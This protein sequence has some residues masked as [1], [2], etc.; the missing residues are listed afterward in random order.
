MKGDE[1]ENGRDTEKVSC[2]T[3]L[4]SFADRLDIVLMFVGTIC[5][6]A[7]GLAQPLMTLILGQIINTFGGDSSSDPSHIIS[8]VSKV[9]LEFVYL[10]IGIAIA[11]FFQVSCWMVTGE[12]QAARIRGLYLK[13]ILRQDITFFDTETTTGEV[14]GRMSGDTILIQDAIGEKVGKTIQLVSTFLGGLVIAFLRGWLLTLVLLCCVPFIMAVLWFLGVQASKLASREQIAYAEAGNIVE[15]TIGAI[16]TVASYTGEKVAIENY[17]RSIAIAYASSVKQGLVSGFGIGVLLLVIFSSYGLAVWFGSKLIIHHGYNGGKVVNVMFAIMTGGMSLGYISPSFKAFVAG[18]AAAY[19]MFQAINRKPLIDSYNTNGTVPQEINGDI[20]LKDVYFSYPAR[21]DIQVFSGF[22]F[23]VPS[24]TTAALVGQ[25]GSGKSTVISLIERFYDPCEGEVLIDGINLKNLQLKWIREKIG[26]VSQE[27]ILFTTTIKGNIAYGKENAT[28]DEIRAANAHNFISGLPQGYDTSVGERGVQ[29]SGGQKQRIAISRAILK[30]P[31]ILLLDEATSALD[32]ESERIVQ[33]ALDKVMVNRTTIVVAHR[34]S[35]IKNADIIAVVKNGVI[36]ESGRHEALM[37]IED[38]AYASLVS[39]H[40]KSVKKFNTSLTGHLGFI[41]I[42][43]RKTKMKDEK[44]KGDGMQ[45]KG[46]DTEKVAYYKL[47]TFADRLD[48]VLMIIGT[49]SAIANGL[50]QPLMTLI[51]GQVINTFGSS[52]PSHIVSD[53]SKVS[54]DFVYLAIGAAIAS[55]CQVSCWMVTGERQAARIRGMYLKTILGQDITFFD[56]ETTTGEVIGRMSGDTILIQDAM[57]EKVGKTIQLLSTFFGGFVIAFIKGWLLALVLVS[58]IP[59]LVAAGGILAVVMSK[60]ASRGQ[61]AYAEAGNIVEQTIGAIRTVASFTG[62]KAAIEKYDR[63][64]AIAYTSAVKQGLASGFGIGSLLLVL[65]STYGLAVWFGSKM[66]I[67]KGYNGGQVVN[68]L[69]AIMTGGMSLGNA[70]PCFNAFASGQAAAYKMFQAINRKPLIDSYDKNGVVPQDIKGDIELKDVYFRY[71]ARPD[72]QIFSGFSLF[73]PSGKTAALVGQSGSGKSTVIS[74]IE[75]FY[76]PLEGE[77]LIDGINLKNLQ[78]KWIREKIGLVSQEPILFTTTIKGNI[79]YG[80]ENATD[81]EIRT[82]IKLA[83]A[84]KFIDKLPKGLD[85]MVGERGT[86]L[87]GGQKQRIAI[88]RAILKNPK[89]LL[90]DEATSALDAESERIVQDAL[91]RIMTN[92]TTVVVAHR[93]T[94]IQNADIIAVVHQGNIIEQGTHAEL[95]QDPEGAYSQL[96]HLQ[97]G[98]K[99]AEDV[100]HADPDSIDLNSKDETINR[101]RSQRLSMRRSTSRGSSSSARQSFSLAYD[102]LTGITEGATG[103]DGNIEKGE[104]DEGKKRNVSVKRLANMNKPE[105]KFLLI[106][107]FGAVV[108][109]VMLPIFGL[110]LSTA[111]K[112]FY[113]P[114][115]ELRKDSKFWSSMFLLLG[116]IVFV[117]IPIEQYFFGVAGGKLIQRIRSLC[118]GKVVYQEIGW[119]DD[120][121]HSSGAIGARLSADATSVKSLVGD[122]LALIVQTIATVLAALIIAFKANWILAFI[123]L[124]LLPL[125]GIQGYVQMKFLNGFSLDAK[126]MYEEASQVANDAVSSIRTVASFCAEQRIMDLYQNKCEAPIKNGVRQGLV[127]GAGYGF[128]FFALYCNNALIFYI[129][130]QLVQHDK[131]TFGE[132]FKVFFALTMA[133]MGLSQT[134]AIGPD[135]NK[136]KDSAASIFELLDRKPKIDSNSNEGTTLSSVTG[137]INLHHISFRYPMR[138]D[139]QIFRDLCLSIPAG[140]TVALVGESGSGKSTVIGLLERFYNPDS[141][142]ITLDGA[143]IQKLKIRWLRQQMGLVSQEPILFNETIRANIAYGKEGGATE[144]EMITATKAANAH[145]FIS[146]LPQ[147]YDTSVGE[148]GVQ[149]S[150]GQK[151]R[152]AISRAI[153]K[154]PRILLLDEATSALDAESERIVQDALDKVMVNRTTIV[155]AHRLSTIKNAD[156]IAVVKNGVIAEKG[157]HETLMKIKDGAYASLVSLHMSSST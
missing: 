41:R 39:L 55:F 59:F 104:K 35:T 110:L 137:D 97:K 129:G 8:D 96:I 29:L 4:F 106:G 98:A 85:T 56:T 124:F 69:F 102:Y 13:T 112:I 111:I 83:N 66:I 6:M 103:D 149:L 91:V 37:K 47:F 67:E 147:G 113:E 10:A 132:V 23:S 14:I 133:A 3:L 54:L 139:V 33:D 156:I 7:T 12:R 48:I 131:A 60:M 92:R 70:S 61:I 126:E 11:S 105:F 77:V 95:T 72:I 82:A 146:G 135:A 116:V 109:G 42:L 28:D 17:N 157:R 22:S 81:D 94:T 25:S 19:K 32:A 26:L 49:I 21:P 40:T 79:A 123:V 89:I 30:D 87:S 18:Q 31:K 5:A 62:E 65:F 57:G 107:S 93:L 152:I 76:D 27:P 90:L 43:Y 34:L 58:C 15:Q 130:A 121:A 141:G 2:F 114:P 119:F 142:F 74:L 143:E 45:G 151:Q 50:A 44:E 155:V 20:E 80:K 153:L 1:Q 122:Y 36:A 16:K 63:S 71:P 9:S 115:Q 101:S 145:N 75:R 108:H 84:A 64:I 150:G 51:F 127:S 24:G 125:V 154:D 52:D 78:L 73:V 128:S 53:V 120:P 136:A 99:Q 68:V 148:R 100:P 138:P 144:E 134:S 88:A 118:F 38:G 140:K 117:F 86:Q 46:R